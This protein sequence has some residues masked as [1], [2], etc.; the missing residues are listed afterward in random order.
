MGQ[1]GGDGSFLERALS[2][3]QREQAR[4]DEPVT[5][6][7]VVADDTSHPVEPAYQSGAE[8]ARAPPGDH[9]NQSGAETVASS[10]HQAPAAVRSS[11]HDS[12]AL[13]ER[14]EPG[15]RRPSGAAAASP[16]SSGA[17][18]TEGLSV[19]SLAL[20]DEAMKKSA[21][22]WIRTPQSPAGRAVWHAWAGGHAFVV[23]GGDEQPDPGFA[24]GR[25]VVVVRSK[26]TTSRLLAFTADVSVA[27]A[28]DADW[29]LATTELA[30]ARLNLRG[31]GDAARRWQDRTMYSITR[32]T[33]VGTGLVEG[34]GH[35]PTDSGRAAPVATVATT[36]GPKPW[37]LHRRGGSGRRLS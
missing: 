8:P 5:A 18:L 24:V 2:R 14:A 26:E 31:A 35:Y 6:V 20:I 28:D 27:G 12:T 30:K 34:P 4:D 10:A 16:T 7:P 1:T 3:S 23:S 36:A 29:A 21:L 33:P 15:A 22:I 17:P 25:A 11:A 9:A 13:P 19:A 37:V 32:L